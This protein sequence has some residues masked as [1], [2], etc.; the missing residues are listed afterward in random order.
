MA[1]RR[2]IFTFTSEV[3][4]E[5]II[6]NLSQQF[7]L[8]TNIRR[9]DLAEERGWIVLELDGEEEDIEAGI[10]WATSKGIRVDPAKD[11]TI[12]I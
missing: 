6:H 7:R 9:A 12:E 3:I 5:P 10:A 1:K 8:I 2:V 4:T 11:E